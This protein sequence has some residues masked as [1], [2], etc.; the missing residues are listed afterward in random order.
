QELR[1]SL[2]EA[3]ARIEKT[4]RDFLADKS[5]ITE[6]SEKVIY[7]IYDKAFTEDELKEL[8]AFYRT[9]VGQKAAVFLPSLS[10]QIQQEFGEIIRAKLQELIQQRIQIEAE[11]M[12]QKVRDA[13]M[14]K[15][16]N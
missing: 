8:I 9:S 1:K 5:Q 2:A 3:I 7:Q 14:K 15:T 11:L 12:K 10:S 6:L 4:S 16:S 13:K